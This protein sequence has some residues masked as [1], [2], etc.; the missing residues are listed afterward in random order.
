MP[1]HAHKQSPLKT[2]P[3]PSRQASLSRTQTKPETATAAKSGCS[4]THKKA[5][6]PTGG[7][8]VL[9]NKP[10]AETLFRTAAKDGAASGAYGGG[11]QSLVLN[12]YGAIS[13]RQT[14]SQAAGAVVRDT[15]TSALRGATEAVLTEAVK[16]GGK[17]ILGKEAAKT[18]LKGSVPGVI[19]GCAVDV[20]VDLCQGELTAKKSA[21]HVGRAASAWAG[22]EAG[23]ALGVFVGGPL[24]AALG[25][26]LGGTLC[27]M[28]FGA[29]FD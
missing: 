10:T 5:Q 7:R 8:P 23:A 11:A 13:G 15:A 1:H 27:A 12:A 6:D 17:R 9:L 29:I 20:A 26:I 28:G 2:D 4:Q 24:G 16:Q 3:S 18:F 19:A 14:A 22:A 21:K 25:G